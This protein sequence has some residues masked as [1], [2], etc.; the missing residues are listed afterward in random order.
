MDSLN[1]KT[2]APLPAPDTTTDDLEV[3]C[4]SDKYFTSNEP[5][6]MT[7]MEMRSLFLRRLWRYKPDSHD[8][9]ARD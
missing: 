4:S 3:V 1:M 5:Y 8:E 2:T 6:A 7:A 9:P